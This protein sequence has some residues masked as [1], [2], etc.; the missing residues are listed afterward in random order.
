LKQ[1]TALQAVLS[2]LIAAGIVAAA[3]AFQTNVDPRI[4]AWIDAQKTPML[5]LADFCALYTLFLTAAIIGVQRRAGA[6]SE[7]L[8]R[9][10][11]EH[12]Q[13]LDVLI[14]RAEELD[15][16]NVE[17]AEKMETL[18]KTVRAQQE[19]YE[20]ETRRLS[21]QAYQAMEE[22]VRANARQLEAVNLAMQYHRAE[23]AQL[24]H[25][26]HVLQSAAEPEL[27]ARFTPAQVEAMQEAPASLPEASALAALAPVPPEA[28]HRSEEKG[29]TTDE[30]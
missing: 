11:S 4:S 18:E 17:Y 21:E 30:R 6:L 2:V 7:E 23:L 9:L 26:L 5:W 27:L 12:H 15:A 20:D 24:R 16:A 28:E 13:Q 10:R 3:T 19:N 25:G 14:T 8:L 29:R 22:A 1:R